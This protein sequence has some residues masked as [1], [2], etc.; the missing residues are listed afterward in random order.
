VTGEPY[1][2]S[3]SPS[4]QRDLRRLPEKIATA[5]VEFIYGSLAANPRRVGRDLRM[6]LVGHRSAR[7]GEYRV[8]YRIHDPAR[9]VH[10]LAVEHRADVY[11]RR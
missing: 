7:R 6:E 1:S 5:V 2:I 8:I 4:A 9:V 3:W 11:R 10:V